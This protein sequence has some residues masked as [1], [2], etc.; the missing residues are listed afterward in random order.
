M[1]IIQHARTFAIEAHEKAGC[2]YGKLPFEY[3]LSAVVHALG[4]VEEHGVAAAWLHDTVEDTPVSIHDIRNIF[5]GKVAQLVDCV[6]DVDGDSREIR[7]AGMYEK[8]AS[9]PA[10]ARRIKLADRVANMT[11]SPACERTSPVTR[12]RTTIPLQ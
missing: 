5:G 9:G 3:H 11:A 8:L 12:L 10:L 1:N 2:T 4:D 6:T 7:K